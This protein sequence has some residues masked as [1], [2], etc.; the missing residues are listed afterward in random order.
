M[1]RSRLRAPAAYRRSA[2]GRNEDRILAIARAKL[3]A[4][5]DAGKLAEPDPAGLRDVKDDPV[6]WVSRTRVLRG[7]PWSWE[8]REYLYDIYRDTAP[9]VYVA[10]GRQTEITEL[11]VNLLLYRMWRHPGTVHMYIS[12][13]QDHTSK[14]SRQRVLHQAILPSAVIQAAVAARRD[15]TAT[16]LRAH[17]GSVAYMV[18]AWDGYEA[19]RS[20]PVDYAYVDEIQ[21]QD[22]GQLAVVREGLAH[23][24]HGRLIGVGTG[25]PYGHAW[26]RLHDSG[27]CHVW[28]PKAGAWLPTNTDADHNIRSYTLPQTV[29]PWITAAEHER[30]R[31]AYAPAIRAMEV[32]GEFPRGVGVP[33]PEEAVRRMFSAELRP[34]AAESIDRKAG[35]VVAGID[36][37]AGGKSDTVVIVCQY[38]DRVLP[39]SRCVHVTRIDPDLKD[40][41]EISRRVRRVLREYA[42]DL[43]VQDQGGNP[44]AIQDVER[45]FGHAVVRCAYMTRPGE[46]WDPSSVRTHNL[47]KIDRTYAIQA[48]IDLITRLAP[49]GVTPREQIPLTPKTEWIIDHCTGLEEE[50]RTLAGGQSHTVYTAPP[51]RQTDAL[52]AMVYKSVA[53]RLWEEQGDRGSRRIRTAGLQ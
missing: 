38:V 29:V 10:K 46:P 44:S 52:M 47:V 28:D 11:L 31:A 5:R 39:V 26:Q 2:P 15:H 4:L 22:V 45:E 3:D 30:K 40:V 7:K 8:G 36:W 41:H 17:N 12:D 19:V 20:V 27:T 43:T 49:D 6:G 1:S 53:Y 42:P 48:Q 13:R 16:E 33:L 34:L 14:F 25:R 35:P 23:S 24:P 51:D 50:T 32:L 37:A 21:S 9:E 18:S